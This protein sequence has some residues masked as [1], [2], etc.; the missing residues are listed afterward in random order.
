[1][2]R[3]PAGR[4]G[5]WDAGCHAL[6][7]EDDK[8]LAYGSLAGTSAVA[9]AAGDPAS[10]AWSEVERAA[11]AGRHHRRTILCGRLVRPSACEMHREVI[12]GFFLPCVLTG[13]I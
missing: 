4:R 12:H 6:L 7:L 10:A 1:M 2:C 5:C 13:S 3:L 9:T 8:K 11:H